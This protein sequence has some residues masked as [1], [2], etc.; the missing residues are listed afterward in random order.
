MELKR[1]IA[2]DAKMAREKAVS[3]YGPDVLVISSG[4]VR[5]QAELIVAVDVE[6]MNQELAVAEAFVP[7]EVTYQ[8]PIQSPVNFSDVLVD[9]MNKNK[10]QEKKEKVIEEDSLPDN[11]NMK[12]DASSNREAL[13]GREIVDMVREELAT[14]RKEFKLSQQMAMWQG[15]PISRALVPL[16]N[17]LQEASIPVS[18]RALLIDSIQNF[19][20][21][22]PA[23]EEIRRLLS[24]ALKDAIKPL[25]LEGVQVIAGPSGTGKSLMVARLAQLASVSMGAQSVAVISYNDMRAGAWNQ[26]QLLS[27]QSGVDCYRANNAGTLKLLIEEHAQRKLIII[28]TPGVQM[29]ERLNEVIMVCPQAQCHAVVSADASQ[30]TLRRIL[31]TL[32]IQ[33]HSFMVTKMDEATQPWGLI[34]LLIDGNVSVSACSRGERISDWMQQMATV[35]LVQ[36]GISNLNLSSNDQHAEDIRSNLAMS[37]SRIAQLASQQTGAIYE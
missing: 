20:D 23:I 7:T 4:K 6:P 29:A 31:Q 19:E 25:P 36:V 28:D 24:H 15:V 3:M 5:G 26:T 30:S 14:L 35:D 2:R 8:N 1:I 34:Q 12:I 37:S 33:W 16:K 27:A 18:L 21:S 17:A 13:R 11:T 9:T 10:R 22:E 32:Q